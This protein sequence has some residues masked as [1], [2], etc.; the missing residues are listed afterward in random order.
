MN[1]LLCGKEAAIAQLEGKNIQL[2][3]G[4]HP[5]WKNVDG[6]VIQHFRDNSFEFRLGPE[7]IKLNGF[8]VK[9]PFVK[10]HESDIDE[11]EIVYLINLATYEG[12]EKRRFSDV[13]MH[14]KF[15]IEESDIRS[16][17]NSLGLCLEGLGH[18]DL[19]F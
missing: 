12:F 8:E 13:L 3:G 11:N 15:W 1:Q 14:S 19:P 5:E 6:C 4:A 10:K 17:V 9:K 18:D 7:T 2:R 16:V